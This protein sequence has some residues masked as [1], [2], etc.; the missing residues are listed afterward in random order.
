ML[1]RLDK[2]GQS[3]TT[4]TIVLI[5]LGI[6]VLVFLIFGFSTGWSSLWGRISGFVG[7]GSNLDSIKQGC[8]LACVSNN[9]QDFCVNERTAK[10]GSEV[11]TWNG[12]APVNASSI[13][14]TCH[15]FAT[16]PKYKVDVES[17]SGL[18]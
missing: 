18:C 11:E 3:L 6:A 9:K 1:K 14:A 7:G 8:E 5:V 15:Q 4:G 17:C 13:S 12:T 10:F 2:K 16:Q